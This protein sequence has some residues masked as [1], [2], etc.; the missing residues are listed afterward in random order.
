MNISEKHFSAHFFGEEGSKLTTEISSDTLLEIVSSHMWSAPALKC[1]R[2]RVKIVSRA[3]LLE[4]LQV[5]KLD[6][7]VFNA[8]LFGV[9]FAGV[10][11][12]LAI[13]IGT[14]F[15]LAILKVAFPRTSVLGHLPGTNVYR[16]AA[17]CA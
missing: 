4:L 13:A 11:I 2:A 15:L 17:C 6:W 7:V 14:S 3:D 1:C 10:E 8:A 9:M 12:G 5:N 16:S